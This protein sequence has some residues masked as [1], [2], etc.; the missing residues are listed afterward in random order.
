MKN[1]T[2]IKSFKNAFNGFGKAVNSERNM[3]IHILATI[4][5]VT[6]G[7]VLELDINTWAILCGAIGLVLVTELM[8]TAVEK[9][10]DMVTSEYSEQAK[11]VKDISAA[12]VLIAAL[13]SATIGCLIFLRPILIWLKLVGA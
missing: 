5:V 7:F 1:K 13:I 12:A 4:I 6:L 11:I 2:L 3:R 9:L 10:T 8:N